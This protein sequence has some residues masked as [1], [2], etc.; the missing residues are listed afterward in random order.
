MFF[1][2]ILI[3]SILNES[4]SLS[5]SSRQFRSTCRPPGVGP[6]AP[7]FSWC[8]SGW[9]SPSTNTSATLRVSQTQNRSST[10]PP[11]W[12][13]TR[14]GSSSAWRETRGSTTRAAWRFSTTP[15]GEPSVTTTSTSTP[16]R[17]CAGSWATWRPSRGPRP[18][19]MGKEKVGKGL[20]LFCQCLS[21][22]RGGNIQDAPT[23]PFGLHYDTYKLLI[24][25]NIFQYCD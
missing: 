12:R 21:R 22:C 4:F 10:P 25:I 18:Q 8:S 5:S 24:A 14:P 20:A 6:A 17:W 1:T 7:S 3:Q 23:C 16:L 13:R 2:L 11:S 19:N 15:R 9:L